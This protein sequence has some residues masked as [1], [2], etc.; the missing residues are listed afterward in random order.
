MQRSLN[1]V[2]RLHQDE[3]Q[4]RILLATTYPFFLA[5]AVVQRVLPQARSAV[6]QPRRSVFAE[7]RAMAVSAIPFVFMG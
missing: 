5:A 1:P 4:A 3:V 2:S 6:A 7:A